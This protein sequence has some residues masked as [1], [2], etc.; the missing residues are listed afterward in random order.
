MV[1]VVYSPIHVWP[2]QLYAADQAPLSSGIPGQEYW[3]V[4]LFLTPGDIPD[5][6][7]KPRSPALPGDYLLPSPPGKP[8]DTIYDAENKIFH[9]IT[10]IF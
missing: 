5:P 4:L 2:L 10:Y 9:Y 1:V 3:S 8:W 6:R 7:I